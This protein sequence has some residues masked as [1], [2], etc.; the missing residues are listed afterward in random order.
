MNELAYR[1]AERRLW[2]SIGAHPTERII[3]LDRIGVDVR[4]QEVGSGPPVLFIHGIATSGVSWAALAARATGFRCLIVDRPGTGLSQPLTRSVDHTTLAELSDVFVADVLDALELPSAHVVASSLGG[5]VALRSAAA[6]PER[7]ERMVQ[8]SWP[9]GAPTNNL[10]VLLRALSLPGFRRLFERL[11][12]TERSVRILL[13][14][15][16]HREKLLDGRISQLDIDCYVALMLHTDTMR[17][18]LAPVPAVMSPLRGLERL[19]LDDEVLSRVVCPTLFVWGARDPFGGE[20]VA[21]AIAGRLPNADLDLLPDAGHSPWLDDMDACV[22]RMTDHLRGAATRH[23]G[24]EPL[25]A[26]AS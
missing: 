23:S 11:P 10:P 16:G 7:V 13:E 25:T 12:R 18:E 26:L 21:R 17:N 6:T 20:A 19:H 9:V 22:L 1:A 5:Y 2:R 8:F 14:R 24:A 3:H 4:L 15:M